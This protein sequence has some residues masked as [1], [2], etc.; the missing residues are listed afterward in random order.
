V[1]NESTSIYNGFCQILLLVK[2]PGILLIDHKD[3]RGDMRLTLPNE[4][5]LINEYIIDWI[6]LFDHYISVKYYQ[7]DTEWFLHWWQFN[8]LSKHDIIY[9]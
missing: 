3:G 2:I 9:A 8:K 6:S 5:P 7:Q 1:R 4:I